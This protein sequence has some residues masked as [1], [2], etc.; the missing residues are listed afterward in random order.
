MTNLLDDAADFAPEL[1]VEVNGKITDQYDLQLG[2]NA[3]LPNGTLAYYLAMSFEVVED[4]GMCKSIDYHIVKNA[5]SNNR[6][7]LIYV[8]DEVRKERTIYSV[9]PGDIIAY[10]ETNLQFEIDVPE[11]ETICPLCHESMPI[12]HEHSVSEF[13]GPRLEVWRHRLKY[14]YIPFNQLYLQNL[15]SGGAKP[16]E[17]HE[18]QL[19]D[20]LLAEGLKVR[21][22]GDQPGERKLFGYCPDFALYS[23]E[24]VGC[25]LLELGPKPAE[26]KRDRRRKAEE[27]NCDVKFLEYTPNEVYRKIDEIVVEVSGWVDQSDL[28]RYGVAD[29]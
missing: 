6:V 4:I 13:A 26:E 24:G 23:H 25:R 8:Y 7:L 3:E 10:A 2:W 16:I 1:D 29:D 5:K 11:D 18:Q 28:T 12:W 21:Y 9:S 20:A 27:M 15:N 14:Y 22:T 19:L 17:D